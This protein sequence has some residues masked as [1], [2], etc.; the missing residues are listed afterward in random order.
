MLYRKAKLEKFAD[1]LN[2]DGL[3]TRVS[4]YHDTA[5]E[6]NTDTVYRTRFIPPLAC[7]PGTQ[8]SQVRSSF[9]HREDQLQSRVENGKMGKVQEWFEPGRPRALKEH[10]H[11]G[12]NPM[13]AANRTMV[14]YS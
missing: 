13:R 7:P 11:H 6:R 3:V 2:Q 10:V 4:L 8:V 9:R 1:Y 5:R 12:S 14:F